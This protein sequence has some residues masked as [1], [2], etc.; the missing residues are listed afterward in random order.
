MPILLSKRATEQRY[1]NISR[2]GTR[3]FVFTVFGK[4]GKN[5]LVIERAAGSGGEEQRDLFDD[6]DDDPDDDGAGTPARKK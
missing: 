6:E 2:I 1:H 3:R 5:R 4:G